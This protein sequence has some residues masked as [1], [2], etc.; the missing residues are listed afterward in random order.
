MALEDGSR[1]FT[2]FPTS[3][4]VAPFRRDLPAS[5]RRRAAG[6]IGRRK[7]AFD[8]QF[9]QNVRAFRRITVAGC[10]LSQDGIIRQGSV[11]RQTE[12]TFAATVVSHGAM[13][14]IPGAAL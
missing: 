14:R 8:A 5:P 6:G 11:S 13:Q 9:K 7:R 10:Q 3:R 4:N 12:F 1:T 2:L